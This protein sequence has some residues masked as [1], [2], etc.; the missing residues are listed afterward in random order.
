VYVLSL[1]LW[2]YIFLT[3]APAS[4]VRAGLMI[5]LSLLGE[6]AGRPGSAINSVSLAAVLL[7]L[8]SPFWFWDVGWRLSVLAAL[9]ISVILER[10]DPKGWKMW[11]G[12]S[13]LIW[14][15]T[16]PQASWTFGSVPLVGVLI[17]IVAPSFFAF[18]LSFASVLALLRLTEIPGIVFLSN[19][20]LYVL[21]GTFTLWETLADAAARWI[22]W[23][24][25]WGPFTAY[26]C[27]GVFLMLL[28]RALFV[29]WRNVAVLTPLGALAAFVL[30][31]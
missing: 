20:L 18:A 6:L 12:I 31:A 5:Q 30:F 27:A 1:F 25:P 8:R 2:I 17:N 10:I 22:P 26:F 7:L 28:C 21:E 9:M 3:G 11:L 13:P 16:F 4:A 29:P 15:T 14:L 23:Q 24:L 19:S